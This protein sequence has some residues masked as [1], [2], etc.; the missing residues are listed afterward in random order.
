[1]Q[2]G[3]RS[4]H[5]GPRPS[6]ALERGLKI[7][8]LLSGDGR[9]RGVSEIA[10]ELGLPKSSCHGLL[11]TLERAGY[12]ARGNGDAW[13]PTLRMHLIGLRVAMRGGVLREAQPALDAL[14]DRTGL[15]CHLGILDG[16]AI[17]YAAKAAPAGIVQF[18]TGPGKRGIVAPDRDR[19][20][21]RGLDEAV[22]ARRCARHQPA[23]GAERQRAA[24]SRDELDAA[25][26]SCASQGFA[27]EDEQEME[28][29]RCVAAPVFERPG[30]RCRSGRRHRARVADRRR[31]GRRPVDA[32][33]GDRE[34]RLGAPLTA[35]QLSSSR[36]GAVVGA[37]LPERGASAL[38]RSVE[39]HNRVFFVS[40][41]HVVLASEG[42]S[43]R[44]RPG[45]EVGAVRTGSP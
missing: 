37:N 17:V 14:R 33:G 24:R 30:H 11:E 38:P 1:M 13:S 2:R 34:R 31:A 16:A 15:S 44:R 18:D 10:R 7:L 4:P 6:P 43:G 29:V 25:S 19:P 45:R 8:E 9:A 40:P 22:G 28:G 20:G 39:S 26:R 35:L 42:A 23:S 21:L 41:S 27:F 12:A 36:G 3:A 32:R 5:P